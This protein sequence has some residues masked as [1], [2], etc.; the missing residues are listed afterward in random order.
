MAGD[1]HELEVVFT[2]ELNLGSIEKAVVIF[3]DEPCIID[4]FLGN[5]MNICFCA[6]DPDIVWLAMLPLIR[7]RDVLADQHAD[8]NTGH[9]KSVKERLDIRIDL[10]PL[11]S[12][13]VFEDTLSYGRDNTIVSPLDAIQSLSKTF[14]VVSHLMRP[15]KAIIRR[16][17]VSS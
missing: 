17:V 1:I 5:L 9:V 11:S 4:G 8:A 10:H 2:D 13:L 12:T 6:D 3:T 16:S 14:I 15:V 7:E